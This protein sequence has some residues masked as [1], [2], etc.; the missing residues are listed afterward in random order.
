M[1]VGFEDPRS[2][3]REPVS[4]D[5]DC[6]SGWGEHLRTTGPGPH[7]TLDLTHVRHIRLYNLVVWTIK[8]WNVNK[9][10]DSRGGAN[11]RT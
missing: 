5:T 3:S 7:T 6:G 8:I 10:H 9:S 4:R 2:A 1:D 11:V